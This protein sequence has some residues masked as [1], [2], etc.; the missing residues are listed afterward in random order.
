MKMNQQN[1]AREIIFFSNAARICWRR[2][3]E[4]G[5]GIFEGDAVSESIGKCI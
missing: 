4:P 1:Y 3:D 5:T 2:V